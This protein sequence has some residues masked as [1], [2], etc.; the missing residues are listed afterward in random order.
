M[1]HAG[2]VLS[3]ECFWKIQLLFLMKVCFFENAGL[4]G[5]AELLQK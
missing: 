5:E 2:A 4:T 3:T 1:Y